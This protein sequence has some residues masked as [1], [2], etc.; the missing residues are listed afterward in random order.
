MFDQQITVKQ[1]LPALTAQEINDLAGSISENT[2]RAYSSHISRL[3][4]F[5]AGRTITDRLLSEY[6]RQ[7]EGEGKS[8]ATISQATAAAKFWAGATGEQNPIG[9]KTE[10]ALKRIRR[11]HS[12]RGQGQPQPLTLDN[13]AAIQ[14]TARQPRARG[15]GGKGFES[16]ETAHTRGAFDI[17]IAG[18]LLHCGLRRS[19]AAALTW[20]DISEG[21]NG[22]LL[23]R[24]AKSKTNQ[25]GDNADIRYCKNGAA[26]AI[27]EIKPADPT[28]T[29]RVLN[30]SPESINRRLKAACRAAGIE[31]KYSAHS[32]RVGMASELTRLGASTT[33]AMLAGGWSTA[34]M[35]AHYSAGAVAE[36]GA[37]AQYF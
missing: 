9:S 18:L 27:R 7:L 36:N 24:I 5:A 16:D 10:T 1:N 23:I 35:V 12:G 20:G 28:P 30:L 17:A 6:C 29:D 31:G 32:G 26:A 13:F 25:T 4:E 11:E 33:A 8:P 21:D 34:R 19:E 37:V 2:R 14:A 15:Q 3:A 22:G